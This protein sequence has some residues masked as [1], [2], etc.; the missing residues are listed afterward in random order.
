MN[1]PPLP[2]PSRIQINSVAP[3]LS[4]SGYGGGMPK[5]AGQCTVTINGDSDEVFSVNGLETL[6]LVSDPDVPHSPRVWETVLT[7]NGA[8]P[9]D[10]GP[11]EALFITVWF[12]CP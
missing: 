11:G 8:G 6:A 3:G 12:S 10:V 4:A 2:G 7:V 5:I 1:L 9:I